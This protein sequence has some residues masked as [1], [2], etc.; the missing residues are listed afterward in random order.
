[1]TDL[2]NDLEGIYSK[3]KIGQFALDPDLERMMAESRNPD[4]LRLVW[5]GW[6]DVSGAKMKDMYAKFVELVNS[7]ARENSKR[8]LYR[9]GG[10]VLRV[11]CLV[12][13]KD[14]CVDP[15]GGGRGGPDP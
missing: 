6:R 7:G 2:G 1:M 10:G 3:A 13:M 4:L 11:L 12:L 5:E 9:G 15:E 8:N 14:T